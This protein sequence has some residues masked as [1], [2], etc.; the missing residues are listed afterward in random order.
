[1]AKKT[2]IDPFLAECEPY[3][4]AGAQTIAQFARRSQED[5]REAVEKRIPELV[6]A[7]GFDEDEVDVLDYWYPD[8]LQRAKPS[9]EICLG[10]KLKSSDLFEASFDRYWWMTE[11]K[12][13][14][15]IQ[16]W[17]WI[18]SRAKLDQL[19]TAID[20]LPDQPPGS[21]N[22]WDFEISG[23]GTYYIIRVLQRSELDEF[24]VR[25]NEF[26]DYYIRLVKKV[27]GVKRFLK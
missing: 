10:V 2:S 13:Q 16:A 4:L 17:T 20:E 22:D 1:M 9:E 3:F 5:F 24:G 21:Q 8:K 15:G 25:L 27:K 23:D 12:E 7:L 11:G 14:I 19:A 18:K 26:I 6:E